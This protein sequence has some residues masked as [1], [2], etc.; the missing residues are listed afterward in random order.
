MIVLKSEDEIK[1][2]A[3]AC[4][5]V[6]EVLEGMKKNVSPGI[7]TKELDEIAES[8]IIAKG[9]RPAFKGYRGY[10]STVC[11][12]VNEQVVHGIPSVKKLKNGDIIS[13]DVG[14]HYNGFYGDAAV[15]LPVG[16]ISKQAQKLLAATENALEAG[17]GKAVVGNRLSDISSTIQDYVESEGFSVVRTFVGHG[18]GR[19]L[20]EEPQI[21][22]YGRPGEGPKLLEG[23]TLAIEPMVNAG[24]WEVNI[25]KDGWT[26]ITKDG[27]LSAH[28]E[29]TVV[30]TNNSQ[31][32]LTK[33]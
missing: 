27:S 9:A 31:S 13:I 26:A 23:M 14:V 25:L 24:G 17:I 22:N 10:P 32:I 15:T 6:A 11:A 20:H 28:F 1:K 12:S 16:S 29:H 8:Y 19:D 7:T 2:M 5:I 30:I 21:P 18:I 4:R 3:E 33:L